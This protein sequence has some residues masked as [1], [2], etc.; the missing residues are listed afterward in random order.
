MDLQRGEGFKAWDRDH[1]RIIDALQKR[2]EEAAELA[3][4]SSLT[5]ALN[6]LLRL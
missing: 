6:R 2:D 5:E 4:E 3:I 1:E